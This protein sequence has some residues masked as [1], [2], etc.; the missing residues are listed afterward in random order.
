MEEIGHVATPEEF[1]DAEPR[2]T[3]LLRK[4]TVPLAVPE[5]AVTAAVR[6]TA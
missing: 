1:T 5:V 3:P 4:D 2:I 6:V